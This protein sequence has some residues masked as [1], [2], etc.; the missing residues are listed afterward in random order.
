L[1]LTCSSSWNASTS[2]IIPTL[3]TST[4]IFLTCYSVSQ[5]RC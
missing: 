3:G 1:G 4:H 5:P 2:S